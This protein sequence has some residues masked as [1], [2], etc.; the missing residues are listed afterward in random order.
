MIAGDFQQYQP[1]LPL[2]AS[3]C[4]II[5]YTVT[6]KKICRK[7]SNNTGN[8][9]DG[10]TPVAC[11]QEDWLGVVDLDLGFPFEAEEPSEPDG[12][13]SSPPGQWRC[14]A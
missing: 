6:S 3:P 4:G 1:P 13:G 11:K 12:E 9:S 14:V 10:R 8:R 5:I 2:P 7:K